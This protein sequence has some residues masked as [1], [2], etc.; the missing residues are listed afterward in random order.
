MKVKQWLAEVAHIGYSDI[1]KDLSKV[2]LSN[3]DNSYITRVGLEKSVKHLAERDITVQ[4]TH[5]TGYS[6]KRR[7]WFGWSH[8]AICG[9][10][11]GSTCHKGDC[12]YIGA[13]LEEQEEEAIRFWKDENH[14]NTT[15]EG[16]IE[17][18][19]E[20]FFEITWT[21]NEAVPNKKLRGQIGGTRHHIGPLG[22]GEWTAET[23][24]DAKQMAIDF[25]EGVS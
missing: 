14:L 9:F 25:N 23:W 12:H 4:L 13:S 24:M 10:K 6:P 22:K 5:G 11:I 3:F 2:Y 16:I 18:D 19:G 20:R 1:A 7:E 21:Y 17:E 15:C 8:R